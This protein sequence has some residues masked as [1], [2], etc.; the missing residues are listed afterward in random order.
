MRNPTDF[1]WLGSVALPATYDPSHEIGHQF[2]YSDDYMKR[3][4]VSEG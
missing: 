3:I 1:C 4:E 2:G